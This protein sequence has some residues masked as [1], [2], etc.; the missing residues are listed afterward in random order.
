MSEGPEKLLLAAVA[1]KIPAAPVRGDNVPG[2]ICC[3]PFMP[4]ACF[5]C[6][7]SGGMFEACCMSDACCAEARIC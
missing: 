4:K 2:Y 7:R 5:C 3:T 6:M 1:P